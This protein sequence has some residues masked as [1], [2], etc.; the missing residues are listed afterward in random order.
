M[1]EIRLPR[2]EWKYDPDAI[3]GRPGGF[4]A[5]F[6]GFG[7]NHGTVAIKKLHITASDAAHRELQI[8][9]VLVTRQLKHVIP[10]LDA[11]MDSESD[12]YFVVM[13]RAEKSLQQG[14]DRLGKFSEE[15]ALHILRDIAMGLNEVSD[16]THRDLKPGNVLY[17]EGQWKIADFGIARFVENATS[18][19][20]MKEAL[21]RQYAAPEQW[22]LERST[23]ATDIYA[24]GC[25]AYALLTGLPPFQGP[26]A[27]DYQQQHLHQAPEPLTNVRPHL[28]SLVASMLR[29]PQQSRP[30]IERVI[31]VLNNLIQNNDNEGERNSPLA[32]AGAVDAE[33]AIQADA[34]RNKEE[35]RHQVRQQ[36]V[37]SA[38]NILDEILNDLTNRILEDAP[39]AQ[40]ITRGLHRLRI[41]FG[42]AS[43]EVTSDMTHPIAE[44]A[45]KNSRWD[46][47]ASAI[48]TVTQNNPT[49]YKW[50]ANLWYTNLGQGEEYRWWEALYF[51]HPL[52]RKRSSHEPFALKDLKDA[53]LAAAPG[54]HNVELAAKPRPIDDEDSE[55]FYNRWMSLL[56]KAYQGQLRHPSSLP[57]D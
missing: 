51:T 42:T 27:V 33:A 48:I 37:Y 34:R 8:A 43:L 3:L 2:G 40:H 11:G 50:S 12:N 22:R 49:L 32:H 29:K 47:V 24:L 30:S 52:I 4:G 23:S 39:T 18:L 16:I 20:T 5:V 25:I 21:T 56:A 41:E 53:D 38:F 55:N 7:E 57:L 54:M 17:H 26:S 14:I 13:S 31:S 46:V 9:D 10:V 1:I 36:L 28:R 19:R 45:F 15:E 6:E 44:D 35:T